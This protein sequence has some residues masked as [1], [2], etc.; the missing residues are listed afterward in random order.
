MTHQVNY[1]EVKSLF[2]PLPSSLKRTMIE[3]LQPLHE[4]WAGGTALEFTSCYGVREYQS[5][6][7]VTCVSRVC[8]GMSWGVVMCRATACASTSQA[9]VRLCAMGCHGVSCC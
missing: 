8:H 9:C 2:V 3:A 7:C 1:H 4:E 5:G 6:V